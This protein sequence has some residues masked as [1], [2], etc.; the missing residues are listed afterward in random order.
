MK[1]RYANI[2]LSDGLIEG[3]SGFSHNG[4]QIND[5]FDLVR[6]AAAVFVPR[7]NRSATVSFSVMRQK[8]SLRA[9]ERL[10]LSHFSDLPEQG[11]LYLWVGTDA[12]GEWVKFAGA[13][14]DNVSTF[15]RGVSPGFQYSFSVGAPQFDESPPDVTPPDDDMKR[16]TEAIANAAEEVEVTFAAPFSGTPIVV[17]TV[18]VPDGG[19]YLTC[20]ILDSTVSSTGFTARLNGAT[21]G[22]GYKL[23]W[24][25]IL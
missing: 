23:S 18:Q 16:G 11:D 24:M 8:G 10:V 9:S 25:A 13:V 21:P 7:G 6:A 12:D 4:Q 15:Y 17:A 5:R 14:I 22:T 2:V 1:V 19:D 20:Q 3:P